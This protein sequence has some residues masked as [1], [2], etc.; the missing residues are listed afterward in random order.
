MLIGSML[1]G[2]AFSNAPCAAVHAL[3]YPLGGFFHVPHG[4]SNALVLTEVL[5]YNLPKAETYYGEIA[6]HLKFGANGTALIDEMAR[7]K[8]TTKVPQTLASVDIPESAIP[9]M[10]KDAMTKTRL[11]M[12]NPREMSYSAAVNIYQAIA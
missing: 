1:A 4:L 6:R 8:E 5:K 7:I 3:A 9:M 11:L 2:Q 10:A 12:N